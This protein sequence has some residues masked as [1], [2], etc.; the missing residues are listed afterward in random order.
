MKQA[1]VAVVAAAGAGTIELHASIEMIQEL[2]FH[3]M[4]KTD[5]RTAVRQARDAA[6]LCVLHD[7]DVA[8]LD[9]ALELIATSKD[10]GG[11]DAVHAATALYH[12]L[13]EILSPDRAF[14][15]V[16]GLSRVAPEDALG[17]A[18]A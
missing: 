14:D 10:L 4:R 6:T 13:P 9:R 12:G 15:D 5:R 11:R 16:V 2:S 3:R 8:V 18:I 7:F 17:S 1:C